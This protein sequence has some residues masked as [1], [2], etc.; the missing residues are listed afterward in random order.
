MKNKYHRTLVQSSVL[1]AA[2]GGTAAYAGPVEMTTPPTP[3][4]TE[5][6]V[7]GSL[8]LDFNSHFFSYG[9]D[10]WNDGS[11]PFTMGFY[12]SAELAF[13][14]PAGFTAT[15]GAWA[16]Y[17]SKTDPAPTIG[18]NIQEIDVWTGL[19]YTAGAFTVGATYQN[20]YYASDVEK[21]LD[22]SFSYD[23]FL[24]PSLTIHNRLDSGAANDEGTILV[25]GLEHGF[26]AG[27]VSMTI[28]FS[29]G[30]LMD[31]DYHQAGAD[32]GFGYATIG[33]QAS[34]PL[35]PYIGEAYGDWSLNAGVT[36]YVTDD[37]VIPNNT[38]ET[39]VGT[40]IGLS[41]SF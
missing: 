27:P 31:D 11:D 19:S 24:S 20:W 21:I 33:L 38:E 17:H 25:L 8:N 34:L 30:Y 16:E 18:G 29:L 41:L 40:N 26:E 10:V 14:L 32:S 23:T 22:I 12:P 3:A 39:F 9:L 36:L 15:I 2:L 6:V 1:A 35:A 13:A 37:D 5:D 28:P 4:P 7:S